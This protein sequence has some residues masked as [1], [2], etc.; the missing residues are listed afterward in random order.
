MAT[1]DPAFEVSLNRLFAAAPGFVGVNSG[2]RDNAEQQ[3]L[4]D[5][6]V[7]KYGSEQAAQKYVARP[8]TSWHEKGLAADLR[9]ADQ[10]TLQWVHDHAGDYGLAF[11]MS[12]EPWHIQPAWTLDRSTTRDDPTGGLTT[13]PDSVTQPPAQGDP[14]G[15]LVTKMSSFLSAHPDSGPTTPDMTHFVGDLTSRWSS[16]FGAPASPVAGGVSAGISAGANAGVPGH[17]GEKYNA[18]A[19]K[20]TYDLLIQAGAT[21]EEASMLAAFAGPE[22]GYDNSKVSPPNTDGTIDQGLFQINSVHSQYDHDRLISDPLYNAK[23]AIDVYRQQ[24]PGAW[25]V[26]N[27]GAYADWMPGADEQPTPSPSPIAS[28]F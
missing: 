2:A 12:W 24:G 27:T 22:S 26:Y 8:G 11:P 9:F 10:R 17:R 4:W 7:K 23:A 6:A 5:A 1:L 19:Y 20:S 28:V 13:P 16:V 18:A 25:T 14:L 3:Q 21:P 15:D